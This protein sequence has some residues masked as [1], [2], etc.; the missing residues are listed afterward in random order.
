VTRDGILI[1]LSGRNLQGR[2]GNFYLT[3]QGKPAAFNGKLAKLT[4]DFTAFDFNK[5]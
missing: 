2:A 5:I 4:T 1:F 3:T